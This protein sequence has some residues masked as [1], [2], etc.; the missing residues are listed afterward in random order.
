VSVKKTG[1]G[2]SVPHYR[3]SSYC[4]ELG[5][6]LPYVDC[7]IW[8]EDS[9]DCIATGSRES[10]NPPFKPAHRLLK[11]RLPFTWLSPSYQPTFSAEPQPF[12]C[13]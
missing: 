11:E 4:G 3:G 1:P 6:P 13:E 5:P 2:A 10:V 8:E 7:N 12:S 9:K